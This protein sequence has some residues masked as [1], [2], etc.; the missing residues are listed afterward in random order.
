[1]LLGD[2]FEAGQDGVDVLFRLVE[3][4]GLSRVLHSQRNVQLVQLTQLL[5]P[6][7]Q[8]RQ[9]YARTSP[10]LHL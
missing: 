8:P 5:L 6:R 4:Q 2:F 10:F 9:T 7:A 3:L 1:M